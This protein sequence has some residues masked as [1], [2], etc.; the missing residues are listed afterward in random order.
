MQALRRLNATMRSTDQLRQ[1][2]EAQRTPPEQCYCMMYASFVTISEAVFSCT[3]ANAVCVM[4][5]AV[6][7][8]SDVDWE[9]PSW[10]LLV[11]AV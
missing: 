8:F 6:G 2:V 10:I 9:A 3:R 7:V 1:W 4:H 5:R 11:A